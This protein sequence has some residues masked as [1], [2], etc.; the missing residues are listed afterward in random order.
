M[1]IFVVVIGFLISIASYKKYKKWINPYT[2]YVI[3][4]SVSMVL[5]L[6]SNFL[7]S[8]LSERTIISFFGAEI[9]YCLGAFLSGRFKIKVRERKV[10]K[11]S[12]NIYWFL[13]I[14]SVIVD[15]FI[16]LYIKSIQSS[17]GIINAFLNLSGYNAFIQTQGVNGFYGIMVFLSTP[18]SLLIQVCLTKLPDIKEKSITRAMLIIQF[19]ICFVPFIGAR[20]SVL[21]L[22]ILMNLLLYY[23]MS[24]REKRHNY[25]RIIIITASVY[26]GLLFFSKTQ[27]LM[28]K[29]TDLSIKC[30]GITV[31]RVLKDA[32]GYIAGN[33]AYLNKAIEN[34]V[35]MGEVPLLAT[36]RVAYIYLVSVFGL[37]IDTTTPF[38]LSFLQIG[39]NYAYSFNTTSIQYYF[40][41]DLGPA[42][43][44]GFLVLGLITGSVFYKVNKKQAYWSYMLCAFQYALVIMSFREYDLI[45]VN[46]I[47]MLLFIWIFKQFN[48][49]T[50]QQREVEGL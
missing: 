45:F 29:T 27:S 30:F 48:Y 4:H 44:L 43:L 8:S 25:K 38:A 46:S 9:C 35:S 28:N 7:N 6:G 5:L 19:F 17:F 41:V 34:G 33:Y 36:L 21:I 10:K 32:F 31:P 22:T 39:K 23:L 42:Y 11:I 18:L 1:I 24:S 12:L 3:P 49:R 15:I 47:I 50:S 16:F 40:M 14:T 2:V 37:N 20:R 26:F 13:G